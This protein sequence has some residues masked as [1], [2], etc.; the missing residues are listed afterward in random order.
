MG[1]AKV[2]KAKG[3]YFGQPGYEPP[4]ENERGWRPTAASLQLL[5]V[6]EEHRESVRSFL[7]P[8]LERMT[9][10][11]KAGQCWSVAQA[12]MQTANDLRI[13]Y[14]EGVWTRAKTSG[15]YDSDEEKEPAPHAWN[16]VDGHVVDLVAEYYFWNSAG[17]DSPWLHEPHKVYTLDD[18][19]RY[20]QDIG[21]FDGLSITVV[22]CAEGWADDYG[23]TWTEDDDAFLREKDYWEEYIFR[24]AAERLRT[25][26]SEVQRIV[27]S[28]K[29]D[30]ELVRSELAVAA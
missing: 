25:K 27:E 11:V 16:L 18:V 21:E 3:V 6:P 5:D 24:G 22:V 14:V 26:A 10:R 29:K 19:R 12:L 20:H 30:T 17:E 28:H 15:F 9:H 1:Q 8:V 2:K 13:S 23:M 4:V 7:H